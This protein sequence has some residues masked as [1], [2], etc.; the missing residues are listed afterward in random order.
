MIEVTN[1]TKRYGDVHAVNDLTFT[2][3]PGIV[4]ISRKPRV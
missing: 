4:T 1:L 2:V 3:Q